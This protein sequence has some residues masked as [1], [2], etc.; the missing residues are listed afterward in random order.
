MHLPFQRLPYLHLRSLDPGSQ[1]L[2]SLCRFFFM[3]AGD[4]ADALVARL[5]AHADTLAPVSAHQLEASL[6]EA[7]RVSSRA[8]GPGST[9][10]LQVVQRPCMRGVGK[11]LLCTPFG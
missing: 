4:W 9:I 8:A 7:I 2:A 6:A 10:C 1:L 3:G 11:D 5:G